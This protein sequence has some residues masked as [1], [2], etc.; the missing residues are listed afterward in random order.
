MPFTPF[1]FGPFAC[2]GVPLHRRLDLPAFLL[3]NVAVD[4]EPLAVMLLRL[5]RPLH[6]YCH[7]FLLAPVVALALAAVLW[8]ARGLV[9]AG[10]RTA[11]LP[12]E[13]TFLKLFVAGLLGASLHVLMDAPLYHDIRPFLPLDVNPLRGAVSSRTMYLGCLVSF[14]PAGMLYLWA[15]FRERR[16]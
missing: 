5:D 12:Y 13:T 7:T 14:I 15:V 8:P 11:G 16:V 6:G 9:K 10:M 2:V 3:A 1:H 4:L